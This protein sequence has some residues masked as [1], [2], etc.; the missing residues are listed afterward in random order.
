[1][2]MTQWAHTLADIPPGLYL[3]QTHTAKATQLSTQAVG[4]PPSKPKHMNNENGS[5][6]LQLCGVETKNENIQ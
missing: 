4:P 1:M 5:E 6:Q 2:S 3:S